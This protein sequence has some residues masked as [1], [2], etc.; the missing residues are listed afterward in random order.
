[1]YFAEQITFQF[2]KYLT[3]YFS[4]YSDLVFYQQDNLCRP[5]LVLSSFF[6]HDEANLV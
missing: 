5:T 3:D 1:M 6:W 2:F 4:D